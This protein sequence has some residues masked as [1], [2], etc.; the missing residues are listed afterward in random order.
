M[1]EKIK[2]ILSILSDIKTQSENLKSQ[3]PKTVGFIQLLSAFFKESDLY[4][5]IDQ[6]A[7]NEEIRKIEISTRPI[8]VV[9]GLSIYQEN[10]LTSVAVEIAILVKSDSLLEGLLLFSLSHYMYGYNYDEKKSSTLELI[11]RMLLDI[12][13]VDGHKRGRK[14]KR[15]TP[16]ANTKVLSLI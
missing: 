13:P 15:K 8:L 5:L 14:N 4:I 12:N 3:Y 7:T 2:N 10:C 11:Q 16:D 1:N 9:Q 6:E